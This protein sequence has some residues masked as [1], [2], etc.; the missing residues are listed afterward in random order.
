MGIF[1]K[2]SSHDINDDDDDDKRA[3][4]EYD[5]FCQKYNFY[6]GK[7]ITVKVNEKFAVEFSANF[8][9]PPECHGGGSLDN[10]ESKD[11][12]IKL[13]ESRRFEP[14]CDGGNTYKIYVFKARK[15]GIYIIKFTSYTMTVTVN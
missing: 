6:H 5:K 11:K 4:K 9:L 8:S 1:H 10:V 13:V 7:E 12:E 3:K 2:S 14:Y 15:K